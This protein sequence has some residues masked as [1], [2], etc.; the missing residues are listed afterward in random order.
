MKY[1]QHAWRNSKFDPACFPKQPSTICFHGIKTN[2]SGRHIFPGRN[3]NNLAQ[4]V[5]P[6]NSANGR[7]SNKKKYRNSNNSTRAYFL[8]EI[9]EIQ[10]EYILLKEIQEIRHGHISLKA[11]QKIQQ[12]IFLERNLGNSAQYI[13]LKK[14]IQHSNIFPKSNPNNAARQFS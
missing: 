13:S 10:H 9:Q 8:K 2:T 7:N 11:L 5:F 14:S 12:G 3:P 4:Y 6:N 1:D